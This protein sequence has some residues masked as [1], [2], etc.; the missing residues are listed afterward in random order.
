MKL[1]LDYIK[2][3]VVESGENIAVIDECHS[4]TY[5][6]LDK[7]SDAIGLRLLNAGVQK[8]QT[9]CISFGRSVETIIA[10]LG[11]LKAGCCYMPIEVD[12]PE[13]RKKYLLD[14]SNSRFLIS[15]SGEVLNWV[16]DNVQIIDMLDNKDE[17]SDYRILSDIEIHKNDP[18]FITYTSGSTGNPKGVVNTHL[19]VLN[20]ISHQIETYNIN[21]QDVFLQQSALSFDAAVRE[22][23][24]ALMSG[25][26]LVIPKQGGQRNPE[27]LCELMI[28]QNVT[29]IQVVPSML[30]ALQTCELFPRCKRLRMI[31]T[32]GEVL[33]KQL[34]D[35]HFAN[36]N[37]PLLNIYGP[38]ECAINVTDYLVTAPLDGDAPI[39]KAIRHVDLRLLDSSGLEVAAG[40]EGELYIGGD[41]LAQG[42]LNNSAATD[43]KFLILKSFGDKRYYR[44]GDL[45]RQNAHGDLVFVSRIDSQVK[46][47][48]VR[49]E[50]GEIESAVLNIPGIHGAAAVLASNSLA[51]KR[52]CLFYDIRGM[53]PVSEQQVREVL[54]RVL[55]Q[56]VVPSVIRCM[57]NLPTLPNDK[58]DRQRLLA[59]ANEQLSAPRQT[60]NE[61]HVR[62]QEERDVH[63]I[64]CSILNLD[65]IALDRSFVSVGG[66][67]IKNF[68]VYN[69]LK[70]QGYRITFDALYA[71]KTIAAQ[72]L[73]LQNGNGID[74]E[75]MVNLE[76]AT[77]QTSCVQKNLLFLHKLSPQSTAY[78]L[79][80]D[81]VITGA[82][83][84]NRLDAALQKLIVD[85]RILL[86]RFD[87]I[88]G[89]FFQA[90]R[91]D[92]RLEII[93]CQST[94]EL[95]AQRIRPFDLFNTLPL[96]VALYRENAQTWQ[97]S[98]VMHHVISDGWSHNLFIQ[99]LSDHYNG[100]KNAQDEPRIDYFSYAEWERRQS[101]SQHVEYWA[102]KLKGAPEL[103]ELPT[104]YS[105]PGVFSFNGA[106]RW[107]TIRAAEYQ[108]LMDLAREE[109]CTP[110]V[111]LLAAYAVLLAKYTGQR[112]MVIATPVTNRVRHEV[113]NTLGYFANTLPIRIG[114]QDGMT[115]RALLRQI[116]TTLDEGML[117]QSYDIASVIDRLNLGSNLGYNPLYQTL[118]VLQQDETPLTLSGLQVDRHR[119]SSQGAKVDI[120]FSL[121]RERHT[122]DLTL[123]IEYATDLFGESTIARFAQHWRNLLVNLACQPDSAVLPCPMM[124]SDEIRY[125]TSDWN[126][127]A[128]DYG[129]GNI[130][131]FIYDS[132][133]RCPDKTA[134]E[135]D[136]IRLS[137]AELGGHVA[138]LV[139]ELKQQGVAKGD[140]VGVYMNRSPEMVVSL[141]AVL[142][143][144]AVYVPMDPNYPTDR[145]EYMLSDSQPR[146][147]LTQAGLSR[148]GLGEHVFFTVDIQQLTGIAHT[149]LV[150]PP[151]AAE[152]A[153]YMIYTSGSTG[154][155][156]GV[157]NIHQGVFNRLAWMQKTYQLGTHDVILQKTP[158]SF[159]VSVWEFFWP[160]M[161]G[162]TLAVAKPEIHKDPQALLEVINRQGVTTLHF[163]PSML[164]LFLE[165]NGI[166]RHTP[167]KRVFCSGEAL[168]NNTVVTF[169]ACLPGVELHNLYGPTEA[170]IDVS[171]WSCNQG[172][173]GGKVPIGRPIDNIQLYILD[174]FMSPVPIGVKGELY[175]A[176][177]GLARG[178]H[179]KPELT[180]KAFIR[181][182]INPALS[183]V[184]YKTGDVARFDH[185]GDIEYLGRIDNQVKLRGLRIE[186]GEIESQLENIPGVKEALVS[187]H[188]SRSGQEQLVAYYTGSGEHDAFEHALAKVL[189]EFMVPSLYIQLD[190][191]PLSPNGKKNRKALPHPD[192]YQQESQVIAPITQAEKALAEVWSSLLK[193]E[194]IS[195]DS[196]FFR[197]GGDSII[198]LKLVSRLKELGYEITLRDIFQHRKLS[199]M[200]ARLVT[201]SAPLL[202]QG[203][204]RRQFVSDTEMSRLPGGCSDAWPASLLQTGMLYH[205]DLHAH[206]YHDVF[207][208]VFA[209]D[210]HDHA[211]FQRAVQQLA[212]K[213]PVLRSA[214]DLASCHVPMQVLFENAEIPYQYAFEDGAADEQLKA[215]FDDWVAMEKQRPFDFVTGPL[216]RI[217][218]LQ[219]RTSLV[220]GFSFHHAILDGWSV[221]SLVTDLVLFYRQEVIATGSV[222]ESELLIQPIVAKLEEEA[223]QNPEIRSFWQRYLQ[224]LQVAELPNLAEGDSTDYVW[225][226]QGKVWP[227][228]LV[229]AV[230]A[231]A[232]ELGISVKTVMLAAHLQ[233]LGMI[234]NT[235]DVSTGCTMNAR[236]A[237]DQVDAA[238]GLFLNTVPVRVNV[239]RA[240]WRELCLAVHEAEHQLIGYHVMPLAD[241]QKLVDQSSLFD[242][243]FNYVDFHVYDR[244]SSLGDLALKHASY[245]EQTNFDYLVNFINNKFTRQM[246]ISINYNASR[247]TAEQIDR[248]LGYYLTVLGAMST[249][250]DAE[251]QTADLLSERDCF[252]LKV[253]KAPSCVFRENS[254]KA[255]FEHIAATY[256]EKKAVVFENR[257]ITYRALNERANRIASYLINQRGVRPTQ[258]V[259]A[260]CSRNLDAIVCLLAIV[261][262]GATY[263]PIDPAYPQ[264]RI[265]YII[266]D[267]GLEVVLATDEARTLGNDTFLSISRIDSAGSSNPGIEVSADDPLYIIYTS[268]STG[269]PKGVLVAN[270]NVLR[271]FGSTQ[272]WFDFSSDDVW[273]LFHSLSFD[274]S[275]WEMW[276]AL[277]YG[278]ELIVVSPGEAHDI[279]RMVDL[280]ARHQVT[281]LSMTP[282]AFELFKNESLSRDTRPTFS[283]RSIIFGGEALNIAGLRPWFE[284]YGDSRPRLINMYGITE[285]TVHV[286]YREI[287]RHDCDGKRSLIGEPIPDLTV[288]LLNKALQPVPVGTPGEIFVGGSGVTLG[289]HERDQLNH[290]RFVTLKSGK[291]AFRAYRSGDIARRMPNGDLEYL[292]REDAQVKI[293]GYRIE[294]Q[295]VD[296][297]LSK[298]EDVIQSTVVV[299]KRDNGSKALAGYYQLAAGV[300]MDTETL[301][302]QLQ[303]LLPAHMIPAYLVEVEN[304][305]ITVNGKLD[306]KSLPNPFDNVLNTRTYIAPE[307]ASQTMLATVIAQELGLERISIDDSYFTLGGDSIHAIRIVAKL[308]QAGTTLKVSDMFRLQ[309]VRKM[310]ESLSYDSQR[311][312][313]PLTPFALLTPQERQQIPAGVVDAYP[314]TLLQQGMIY[315][316]ELDVRQGVFHD[317]LCYELALPY[318]SGCFRVALQSLIAAHDVLRTSFD[319]SHYGQIMQ[320]VHGHVSL[321]LTEMDISNLSAVEQEHFIERWFEQEK[322]AGFNWTTAPVG[323]FF[324]I[325]CTQ[326]TFH[327]AFSFNHCILDGWSLANLMTQLLN[328]YTELLAGKPAVLP[329]RETRLHYRDV[330][331]HEI[332]SRNSVENATFWKRYLADYR[333]NLLPRAQTSATTRWSECTL[334]YAP[335]ITT[336]LK[337]RANAY[338]VSLNQLLLACHCLSLHVITGDGDITTGVF[339]NIRLEQEGGDNT[340]GLHLNILPFRLQMEERIPMTQ[341]VGAV[342]DHYTEI[343]A[344]RNYP[345]AMIQRDIGVPRLTETAFNFTHFHVYGSVLDD[346]RFIGRIRWFEHADFALL[347]NVGIDIKTGGINIIFNANGK[348]L[349]EE[350]LQIVHK[351]Y[352]RVI[353]DVLATSEPAYPDLYQIAK[354]LGSVG[355]SRYDAYDR[356]FSVPLFGQSDVAS[357]LADLWLKETQQTSVHA[358]LDSLT[359]LR[360]SVR[361]ENELG[362]KIPFHILFQSNAF[363]Q[364]TEYL[365]SAMSFSD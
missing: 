231:L 73:I 3:Q 246:E 61:H 75:Q 129:D 199:D 42:Y 327:F 201:M 131:S 196:D 113:E 217:N 230:D 148:P 157:V 273:T 185:D 39:G 361:I 152:D 218:A 126:R 270:H 265:D 256:P 109:G 178:Y 122:D 296:A 340:I 114:F 175:I 6:Q 348:V 211:A 91:S 170:A 203:Y 301:R 167:L 35:S 363:T 188:K 102:E 93:R 260:F 50:L 53:I 342:A 8:N 356:R 162:A 349:S 47:R 92:D 234:T 111:G 98:I 257:Y 299:L 282:S 259:G 13:A 331:A 275:V 135:Y 250:P 31:A 248:Y 151:L 204:A 186:L 161:Y 117:H 266:Q 137:Y 57:D 305:G 105:R 315:H 69:E 67:S 141:L 14:N 197:L 285:T 226:S 166:M 97:L 51:D 267:A 153:A 272:H 263:V 311:D 291:Q 164:S 284:H 38:T 240:N 160:L 26:R 253:P 187:V 66:D 304:F 132:I 238:A 82:L 2:A 169:Q 252:E 216:F 229:T 19:G 343:L 27:Y 88:D 29:L 71:A 150:L 28:R 78:N 143:A 142:F 70:K 221:A 101:D 290:E 59:T 302:Q 241:I 189:P 219:N 194:A 139:T 108:P 165:Q 182:L 176:G 174:E 318:D 357:V 316:S 1:T 347:V 95:M 94:E 326:E 83:D 339:G 171:F 355:R 86:T 202:S 84:S 72:A 64:W 33:D 345:Y 346:K 353:N 278:G 333:Y 264:E 15:K 85:N 32:G 365:R 9:V 351:V 320:I 243:N 24:C 244:L 179:N 56:E 294:V 163:V 96:R 228:S 74:A 104:D 41:C 76:Q 280:T 292:G 65:A 55:P 134:L 128:Y 225:Q 223:R 21:Y 133:M 308:R 121:F 324:A 341:L 180:A 298:V 99:Q 130:V 77:Y 213:H 300:S 68:M 16:T 127:T 44:T 214:F 279:T 158:F 100:V 140:F 222:Q 338:G 198:S 79:P 332:A 4:V 249:S 245:F 232:R 344:H 325:R 87:D 136:A 288:S 255:R 49:I 118:F 269:N 10:L 12:L 45:V 227:A 329:P 5:S 20:N 287:T 354:G 319:F 120:Q 23:F 62:T 276:G 350:Q 330:V 309:T 277:L 193:I 7:L 30:R 115:L 25:G 362:V 52:I 358:V 89:Q 242:S 81:F 159:D 337:D 192:A 303:V 172:L 262:T 156:K 103:L 208:F 173:K 335:E 212:R 195:R 123:E 43:E 46:I 18:F 268:G 215:A 11:V 60:I 271:L 297:A 251:I 106:H 36:F 146:L 116:Q 177:V 184:M 237:M 239:N 183:P 295:E 313:A 322:Q 63:R 138:A 310:A 205:S 110:Y 48:G 147:V 236:P 17:T 181:N 112:D 254:I 314:A 281:R 149:A 145:I 360:L 317:L 119:C 155:P 312:V 286:T 124:G 352:D 307:N 247:F 220:I 328:L 224:A 154:N 293:N 364:V 206:T 283:L 274:F 125:I 168:P 209:F 258:R 80:M 90:A 190:D 22:I 40:E 336:R 144:E 235:Y 321:P 34:I 323:R 54:E 58:I 200:A 306:R 207:Y 210:K 334:R 359:V 191:F 289:Y 107:L 37:I 233:V 261:K